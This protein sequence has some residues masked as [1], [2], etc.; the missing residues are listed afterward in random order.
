MLTSAYL[1]ERKFQRRNQGIYQK[2]FQKT[3]VAT[4]DD[5][6]RLEEMRRSCEQHHTEQ[7]RKQKTRKLLVS[8]NRRLAVDVDLAARLPN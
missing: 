4:A 1:G 8:C 5:D 2:K 3:K 7:T 6:H